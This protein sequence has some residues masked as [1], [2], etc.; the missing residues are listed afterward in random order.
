MGGGNSQRA[1]RGER[2]SGQSLD[3]LYRVFFKGI[4]NCENI[5]DAT[6]IFLSVA[7]GRWRMVVF[8]QSG[9]DFDEEFEIG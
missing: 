8:E 3:R 4:I 7:D 2:S 6:Y 1:H 9:R 5:Y